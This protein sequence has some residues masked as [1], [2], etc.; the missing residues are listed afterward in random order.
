VKGE[1]AEELCP[2]IIG[3][4]KRFN[5][6]SLWCILEVV[7]QKSAQDRANV[8]TFFV[9][10]ASTLIE[11]RNFSGMAAITGGLSNTCVSRLKK[12]FGKL[13]PKT[14]TKYKEITEI[15]MGV[16]NF[17]ELR[18]LMFKAKP[19]SIPVLA[20]LLKDLIY[21]DEALPSQLTGQINF[22]KF[23]K[24]S[25]MIFDVLSYQGLPY[26]TVINLPFD[27]YITVAVKGASALGEKGLF[28]LSKQWE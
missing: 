8:V 6:I 12:T 15:L 24:I 23:R 19:P 1:N 21:V 2:G 11:L 26:P 16:S 14:A 5:E 28:M 25:E 4:T 7:S 13:S 9:N 20:V 22:Y 27:H 17:K 3:I 10:L 18:A